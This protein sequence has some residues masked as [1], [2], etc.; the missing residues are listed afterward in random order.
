MFHVEQF[1]NLKLTKMPIPA[2][3]IAAGAE[4]INTSI[5]AIAQGTVNRK[6]REWQE[7]MYDKQRQHALEDREWE[8][9]Y[10]D[11]SQQAA[12][13]EAAGFNKNLIAGVK[14][15]DAPTTRSSQVGSWTPK[16]PQFDI[17]SAIGRYQQVQLQQAQID[18]TKQAT[19]NAKEENTLLRIKQLQD[20]LNVDTSGVSN[21]VALATEETQVAAVKANLD[22]LRATTGATIND[23][24]RKDMR[25]NRELNTADQ[26]IRE[27]RQ[28]IE[29]SDQ[30]IKESNA[31]V[32]EIIAQTRST[33]K[34]MELMEAHINNVI[35]DTS[36]K[37]QQERQVRQMVR[38]LVAEGNIEEF[39]DDMKKI[40][41][42]VQIAEKVIN[43]II[44]L[45]GR[46]T[47]SQGSTTDPNGNTWDHYNST[48]TRPNF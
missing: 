44:S 36:L 17:G 22:H 40:D 19:A 47:I 25:L 42:G 31:R 34:G 4:V 12:R 48:R 24:N 10:N 15:M 16:A 21:R 27:S 14:P 41:K 23:E 20:L 35:A 26:G 33:E 37:G 2:G 39:K 13:M 7:A 30:R 8:T 29:E 11:P 43:T 6:Q 28:R 3:A 45:K 38:K 5:N 18:Q 1:N 9:W 46:S 32:N